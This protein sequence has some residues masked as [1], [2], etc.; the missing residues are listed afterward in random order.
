MAY[1][2]TL[3][4]PLAHACADDVGNLDFGRGK[5]LSLECGRLIKAKF[6]NFNEAWEEVS[7]TSCS[8][9][10]HLLALHLSFR[11][12]AVSAAAIAVAAVVAWILHL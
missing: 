11:A 9:L 1:S 5:L 12:I 4:D 2:E 8:L 10:V 3:F 6:S 7:S